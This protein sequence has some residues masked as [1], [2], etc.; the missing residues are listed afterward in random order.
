[1]KIPRLLIVFLSIICTVLINAQTDLIFSK[2]EFPILEESPIEERDVLWE[3]KIWREI[4]IKQKMNHHFAAVANPLI[5]VLFKEAL[6]GKLKLYSPLDDKFTREMSIEEI[7]C[8]YS[9]KET[10]VVI[11]PETFEEKSVEYFEDFNPND[12]VRYRIKEVWYFDS[13]YSRMN[14]RI[15]GFAPVVSR[16]DDAG[17][18]IAE[19]PIFWIYYPDARNVLAG[20]STIN[21]FNESKALSWDDIFKIRYFSSYIV[22]ENNIYDR[23]IKDYKEGIHAYYEAE[24]IHNTLFNYEQDLWEK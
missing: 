12:V 15:L 13:K 9:K 16:Y 20:H 5:S 8:L 22:K 17:R 11:D 14:V 19:V 18:L 4:D 2:N 10:T 24:A 7:S 6:D 1:M 21:E 23:R 3:K